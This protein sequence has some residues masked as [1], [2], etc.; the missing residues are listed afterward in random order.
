VNHSAQLASSGRDQR[1]AILGTG[2]IGG[3][4]AAA[5]KTG[6]RRVVLAGYSPGADARRALELGLIDEAFTDPASAVVGADWVVLAAPI[7]ALADLMSA[8]VPALEPQTILTDCASTKRSVVDAARERLGEAFDRFVPGHPIAGSEHSGPDAARHDLFRGRRWVLCPVN[9]AQRS[10]CDALK[11]LL[12]P[13]GAVMSEMSPSQHDRLF[14]EVSH[15]PHVVAFA[16]GASIAR[17]ELAQSAIEFSGGGLRDT[18]RIAASSPELW[19]G[20]L[21]DNADA[22]LE[23]AERYE[24]ELTT[25]IQALRGRDR[26]TLISVLSEASRWRQR[27][28]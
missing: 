15:W 28:G 4:V 12:S 21:L 20:I 25:L 18:S 7:P 5:L 23:S 6:K 2:L 1:I 22:V 14:A 19:A 17:G 3:S 13:T 27:L 26:D 16:L 24:R 8:I 11:E 9:D 10:H